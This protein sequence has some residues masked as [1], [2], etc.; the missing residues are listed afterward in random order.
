MGAN[1]NNYMENQ[2]R[3]KAPLVCLFDSGIGGLNLLRACSVRMPYVNFCYFADNYNVPYGNLCEGEIRRLVFSAFSQI[4]ALCPDAAAVA[5]NT[6]TA[7]CVREL[8]HVFPFPVVGVEPAV[9]QAFEYGGKYLVL[10]TEATCKSAVFFKLLSKY[11]KG[12][13]VHAMK[14]LAGDIERNIFSLDKA[15][16][17]SRLPQGNFSSVVL[18]C[19]HYIFI[20]DEIE[21][22][23]RCPVF[24]G[25][26]GTADHLATILGNSGHFS[27]ERG[28]IRFFGGDF[29][30][31]KA[32]FERF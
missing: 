18:G 4:A 31:N 16:L 9:K 5:C 3:G 30:K 26:A 20:R 15:A 23:Y 2:P 24:D 17:A 32:V 6:V 28:K 11:G 13:E 14:S 8:R 12:A 27:S 25:M 1:I 7:E 19:T 29:T 21:K 10:A 22:R